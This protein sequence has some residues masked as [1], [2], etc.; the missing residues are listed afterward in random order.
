MEERRIIFFNNTA[1]VPVKISAAKRSLISGLLNK[2]KENP[3]LAVSKINLL[4]AIIN[5][6]PIKPDKEGVSLRNNQAIISPT[7]LLYELIGPKTDSSP[8][9]I[10]FII[11]T[12]PR[13]HKKPAAK[14]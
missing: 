4:P 6:I 7:I 2:E 12:V 10:A 9:F 14:T 13:A 11:Q 8:I 5:I 1:S 3:E